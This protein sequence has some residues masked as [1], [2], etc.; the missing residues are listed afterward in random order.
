LTSFSLY[1]AHRRQQLPA[2]QLA[3]FRVLAR[4]HNDHESHVRLSVG[5]TGW[6]AH[7]LVERAGPKSTASSTEDHHPLPGQHRQGP[8]GCPEFRGAPPSGCSH[9]R[10]GSAPTTD[11]PSPNAQAEWPARSRPAQ[12]CCSAAP[13]QS[14]DQ[15]VP[16]PTM[17]AMIATTRRRALTRSNAIVGINSSFASN[18]QALQRPSAG[19]IDTDGDEDDRGPVCFV[20][21]LPEEWYCKQCRQGRHQRSKGRA[22]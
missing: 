17:R 15:L 7:F 13:C 9:S 4:L 19:Q 2:R 14:R 10:Y 16:R 20:W 12:A 1:F 6:T 11:C 8:V 5:W 3:G 21:P 22:T 18:P